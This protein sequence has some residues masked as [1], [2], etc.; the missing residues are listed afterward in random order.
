MKRYLAILTAF[1]C[2]FVT[3]AEADHVIRKAPAFTTTGSNANIDLRNSGVYNHRIT[4]TG[5]NISTCSIKLEQSDD[6]IS[7]WSD[8]IAGQDCSSNGSATAAGYTSYVR[9]TVSTLTGTGAT[10]YMRYDGTD[11]STSYFFEV[12]VNG[13]FTA[14]LYTADYTSNQVL[15]ARECRRGVITNA[16]ASG[17]V[18][19]DLPAATVGMSVAVFLKEAQDVDIDPNGTDQ[20]EV[21]TDSGGDAISS[22]AVVGSFITLACLESGVWT[23]AGYAGTWTDVN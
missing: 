1:F 19:F 17:A 13:V 3:F 6:G 20:I 18:E 4:W 8:L 14:K 22:D 23:P 2:L 5:N 12:D 11:L 7:G 15:V 16:G 10:L 9:M 21:L